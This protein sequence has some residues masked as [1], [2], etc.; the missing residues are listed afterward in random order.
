MVLRHID[1]IGYTEYFS[2]K[3]AKCTN[4]KQLFNVADKLLGRNIALPL[5]TSVSVECLS[6]LF[7]TFFHDK[8]AKIREHLDSG[9]TTHKLPSLYSH[10]VECQHTSLTSYEP[11]TAEHLFSILT[12]CALKSCD[13]DPMPASLLLD[14]LNVVLS[15][16]T[17]IIN[18]SL[19][20]GV[21]PSFYKSAIVKPLLKKSTLDANDMKNYRPVSNLS[22]MS[23]ILEKVVTHYLN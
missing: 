12:K 18:D 8:V 21:F 17:D 6:K 14:H 11:V 16:M 7:S 2:S 9:T 23:K 10:D 3:I 1:T 19:D 5:P 22:F 15:S 4:C 20:F 13:L